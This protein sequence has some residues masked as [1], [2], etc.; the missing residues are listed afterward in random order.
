MPS[1]DDARLNAEGQHSDAR[2]YAEVAVTK[3]KDVCALTGLLVVWGALIGAPAVEPH[4][5]VF[6]GFAMVTALHIADYTI[7]PAIEKLRQRWNDR[8]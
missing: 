7:L 4:I 3:L 1:D 2:H 8:V 5:P 6:G